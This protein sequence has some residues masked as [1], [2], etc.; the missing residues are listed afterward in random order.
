[1]EK[2]KCKKCKEEIAKDAKKCPHCGSKQGMP[3]WL[4][5]VIVIVVLAIIAGSGGSNE[6]SSSNNDKSS[7]STSNTQSSSK[8]AEK[9]T[10]VDHQKS[11]DSNEFAYYIEGHIK[12]NRDRNIS[13]VQVI[14]NTYDAEGNTIGTCM[15]NQNGLD[16]NGTWKFKAMCLENIDQ[17]ARYELKEITGY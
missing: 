17:I 14:F 1:M 2:K 9:F 3:K 7:S 12:N 15:D 10:L 16:A 11:A 8:P 6:S 4:I 13:Y 5:A